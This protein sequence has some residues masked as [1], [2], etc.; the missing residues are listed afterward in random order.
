MSQTPHT[1]H[2]GIFK[3]QRYIEMHL[4]HE[5]SLQ[6][7]AELACLSQFHFHRVFSGFSGET[8][9]EYS[10][11]LRLESAATA[12]QYTQKPVLE[13][14]LASGYSTH[15]SFTRAFHK[16]FGSSPTAFRN[17]PNRLEMRMKSFQD[18][19]S[20]D[21]V[22]VRHF[23]SQLVAFVRH[24]GPY[25]SVGPS[26]EVLMGWAATAGLLGPNTRTLGICHDDPDVVEHEKLRYD[27]CLCLD[28]PCETSGPIQLQ[29]MAG[30]PCAVL[31]VKGSY[32]QLPDAYRWFYGCWLPASGRTLR[33]QPSFELFLTSCQNTPEDQWMTEIYLPLAE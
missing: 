16:R 6:E 30:G 1:Y 24:V 5:P 11:R 3:V 26:F 19:R 13:V 28:H 33:D 8:V 22:Q 29:T 23:D 15:E 2:E 14:A 31:P 17:H 10:R 21:E 18:L 32:N 12:L 25:Q 4:D 7:L 27:C 9:A 20:L